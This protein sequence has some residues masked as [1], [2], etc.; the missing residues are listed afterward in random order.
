MSK[1]SQFQSKFSHFIFYSSLWLSI[2]PWLTL[3]FFSLVDAIVVIWKEFLWKKRSTANI[4]W[5]KL[6]RNEEST[7]VK[8]QTYATNQAFSKFYIQAFE[9]PRL[10]ISRWTY[11]RTFYNA[12]ERLERKNIYGSVH[13]TTKWNISPHKFITTTPSIITH[14]FILSK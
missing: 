5:R 10:Y 14:Q 9:F 8:C 7:G 4:W 12:L 6:S 11:N 3:T 13:I 2:S 1:F